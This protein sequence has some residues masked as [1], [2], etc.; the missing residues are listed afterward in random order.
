MSEL[1]VIPVSVDSS[2]NGVPED[3]GSLG[4]D[5][6]LPF[7][8]LVEGFDPFSFIT[9]PFKAV[10]EYT[11]MWSHLSMLCFCVMIIVFAIRML[12]PASNPY[13]PDY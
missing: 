6:D 8:R 3:D 13:P 11:E 2:D 1:D 12:K 4:G 10:G 5:T 7:F 9:S